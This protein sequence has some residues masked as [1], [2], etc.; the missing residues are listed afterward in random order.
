[1]QANSTLY[2][3]VGYNCNEKCRFCPCSENS[4]GLGMLSYE[5]IVETIDIAVDR[6][7][8]TN[9]LLSGGE[10]TIHPDFLKIIRHI[11]GKGVKLSLLTNALRLADANFADRLFS[12]VD[13]PEVDVTV[14]FHSHRPERHDMLTQVEGSF[15]KSMQGVRNMLR[16][17]VRLSVKNNI[18]NANYQY[19][20]DYVNWINATFDD[21][22]TLLF[23][24]IDINGTAACNK[25]LV[26]VS[27][28]DS[29]PFLQKALDIVVANRRAGH[30][31]NVKVLTTPLCLLD[32]FYWGFVE[33]ATQGNLTAY[34]VP[35]EQGRENLL[36]DVGSDSGPMFNACKQCALTRHCPGTWRSFALN[37]D[38]TML[39][40][41]ALASEARS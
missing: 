22:V 11:A 35:M 9:V 34:K 8:I 3:A 7:G 17:G 2:C 41:L 18:V 15:R 23:A 10:P 30:K 13:G 26:A 27:F 16:H 12:L 39:K 28:K 37:F 4:S 19:L 32:P 21:N 40:G 36:F 31:R 33:T 6:H 5:E 25:D 20:P 14:A 1:M 38:E 24:N 29:V